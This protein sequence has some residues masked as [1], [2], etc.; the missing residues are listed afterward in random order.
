M[1]A[2]IGVC[3]HPCFDVSA[4]DGTF[5]LEGV[6]AGDHVVEVWHEVFGRLTQDVHVVAGETVAVEFTLT[7]T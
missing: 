2:W 7:A 5:A 1:R 3:R 6:P 4:A